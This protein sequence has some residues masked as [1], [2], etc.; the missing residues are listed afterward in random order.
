MENLLEADNIRVEFEK[1]VAVGD[2][3]FSMASGD[4]LGLIG[5]NGAGKTTLL[6]V[7][8][9]LQAPTSGTARVMGRD[10]FHESNQVRGSIGFSPDS[11]PA[12]E[13]LTV[14]QFLQFIAEA[15][16][17]TGQLADERID[18]WLE[19]VWL[20][21]KRED[22]IKS[23]SRGM[24]QRVTIAQTMVPNPTVVLFDEPSSGLDPAGRIQLRQVIAD[25]ARS[26]KAVIVSSH[27]LADLE[28]FCTHI[29]IIEHGRV[30]RYSHVGDLQD[31]TAPHWRYRIRVADPQGHAPAIEGIDG[32]LRLTH[33]NGEIQ[34]EYDAGDDAA[35]QLLRR[36]IELRIPVSAF[37]PIRETLED[38]YLRTGVKQVD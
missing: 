26:G 23:L 29:A 3:S 21:E 14:E 15:N 28:E 11:P 30:L 19:Q 5:P 36:L 8:V 7:L 27:I 13:E 34:L 22:R 37:T 32:V 1:L 16:G 33:V 20:T 24:R 31:S 38:V 10:V 4:L 12:Y 2:V 9:G 6:R 35:S 17:V 25:L 18:H